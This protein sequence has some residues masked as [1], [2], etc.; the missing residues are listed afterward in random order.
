MNGAAVPDAANSRSATPAPSLPG[1][2]ATTKPSAALSIG[3]TNSGRPVSITATTGIPAAL[4][5]CIV[6][7]GARNSGRS[8]SDFTSPWNSA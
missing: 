5:R 4:S 7:S 8:W 2:H 1:S 6:A 3:L